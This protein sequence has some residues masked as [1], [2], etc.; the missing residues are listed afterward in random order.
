MTTHPT[1]LPYLEKSLSTCPVG[2]LEELGGHCNVSQSLIM[3]NVVHMLSSFKI[4]Y[5]LYPFEGFKYNLQNAS[6]QKAVFIWKWQ[7]TRAW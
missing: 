6:K 3:N 1:T 7:T 5:K 2:P 4:L